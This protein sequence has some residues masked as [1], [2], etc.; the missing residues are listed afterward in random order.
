MTLATAAYVLRY[1]VD[2]LLPMRVELVVGAV[3]YLALLGA[4]N[5]WLLWWSESLV[6]GLLSALIFFT[7]YRAL[8][9]A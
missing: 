8:G 6:P 1:L 9:P 5:C 2:P 3:F 7:A 4:I